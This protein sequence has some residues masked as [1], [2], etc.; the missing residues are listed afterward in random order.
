MW[1]GDIV[2]INKISYIFEKNRSV[3]KRKEKRK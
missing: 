3:E 1:N 2:I